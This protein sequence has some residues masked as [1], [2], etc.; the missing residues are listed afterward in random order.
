MILDKQ[1]YTFDRFI[2]TAMLA[3]LIFAVIW[4]L[5]YLSDVLIPFAVALL[6]AYLLNP[7]VLFVQKKIH[8][9]TAAVFVSLFL[10]VLVAVILVWLVAPMISREVSR[11]STLVSQLFTNSDLAAQAA[12]RLP[13][14]LWQAIKDYLAQY[15]IQRFFQSGGAVQVGKGL[16]Q[17]L[18]PGVWSLITGTASFV[19]AVAGLSLICLYLVFLLLDFSRVQDHWR[20]WL[21]P[22]YRT[23][24]SGFVQDFNTAMHRYFRGQALIA[25]IVGVL[26]AIGFSI[27][28]LPLGILLG[29]FIGILNMVPYLQIVGFI[30]AFL[31]AGIHALDTG[32]SFWLIL[33]LTVLVF[34]VV[35]AVQDGLLV[36]KIMGN[37]TGL[38][39]AV[40]LLSLSVWGKLL[41]IF[42]LLIALPMTC[43]IFAYYRR[44]VLNPPQPPAIPE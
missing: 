16:A 26:F 36:P 30:P 20:D 33:G 8:R 19:M 27:I 32:S 14:D 43:L 3:G 37:V 21:P 41:G 42:G 1:P 29:L 25:A 18:L 5:G 44:F 13:P 10:V 23:V 34:A 9:R 2:R 6:L 40:I 22:S 15:D 11:T 24:I 17:K 4:L 12:K 38:S 31:L 35:Q 7:L 39:P 28:G